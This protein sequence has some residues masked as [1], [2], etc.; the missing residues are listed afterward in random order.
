MVDIDPAGLAEAVGPDA[1]ARGVQYLRQHAVVRALWN[2]SASALVGTVRGRHGNF[3]TTTARFSV[4]GLARRFEKGECSCPVGFNCKHVA[5]LVLSGAG[6]EQPRSGAGREQPRGGASS[7]K[8]PEPWERSL[9]SLLESVPAGPSNRTTGTPLAI[10]LT[11]SAEP[12]PARTRPTGLD[13]APRLLA[14]PVRPGKNGWVAGGLSWTQ[15]GNLHYSGDY[16]PSHVRL[17]QELHALYK[18][19]DH[20][21]AYSYG[22]ER[23]VE[24]SAFESGQLWP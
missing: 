2:P 18:S 11:L 6:R 9:A 19:R 21:Y 8:R 3:Y 7:D 4:D 13:P 16:R 22:E 14:R 1:H 17:L 15:L 5:A 23:T 12:R 10:E 20:R 24:L